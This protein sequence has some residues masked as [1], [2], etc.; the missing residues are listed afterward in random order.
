MAKENSE[1]ESVMKKQ[2]CN[3]PESC[4]QDK[5]DT[6]FVVDVPFTSLRALNITSNRVRLYISLPV[7]MLKSHSL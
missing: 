4:T 3:E 5:P 6:I 1:E 2:A 7:V